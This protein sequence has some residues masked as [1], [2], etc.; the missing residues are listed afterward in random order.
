MSRFTDF[1]DLY[2][3]M[4]TKRNYR[5][6]LMAYMDFIYGMKR[7]RP[8]VTTEELRKYEELI[9][10]YSTEERDHVGD[11]MRF[12]AHNAGV[13]V[14]PHTARNRFKITKEFFSFIGIELN[15][16]DV[17]RIR[18]KLPKGHTRTIERDMDHE[19]L[20]SIMSHLDV[21]SRAFF[22][23][24]AS[25]GMRVGELVKI[26]M[27]DFN[28]NENPASVLIRGELTRTGD[29]RCTFISQEALTAIHEWLKVRD[30]YMQTA[31]N[32]NRGFTNK[33]KSKMRSMDDPRM[34]PISQKVAGEIWTNALKNAGLLSYDNVTNRVQIHIHMLRKFF[35]SQLALA[36]PVDIVEALMGHSGYLTDAYRRHTKKQ[37]GEFYLKAEHRVTISGGDILGGLGF[38][39]KLASLEQENNEMKE[40]LNSQRFENLDLKSRIYHLEAV[41]ATMMAIDQIPDLPVMLKGRQPRAI[42]K[43]EAVVNNH[44]SIS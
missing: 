40:A 27:A 36:C 37:M 18:N 7:M 14:T 42:L 39:E 19:T 33:D 4:N 44:H 11:L 35:R 41:M 13:N 34:F 25:S 12:N 8:E 21:K 26:N 43:E 15:Q 29:Q 2:P 24:L 17:K 32:R 22:L 1:L 20:R 28:L 5:A 10:Q 16:R 31:F 23:T 38:G 6:A 3:V 30:K 9:E